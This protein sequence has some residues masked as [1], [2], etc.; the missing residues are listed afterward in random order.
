MLKPTNALPARIRS[1]TS[2]SSLLNQAFAPTYIGSENSR[3]VLPVRRHSTARASA[4]SSNPDRLRK[5]PRTSW[6]WKKLSSSSAQ[7][8]RVPSSRW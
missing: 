7:L 6:A 5:P 1:S 2:T 3:L 4:R 8:S